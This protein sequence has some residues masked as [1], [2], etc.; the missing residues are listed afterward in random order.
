V[1]WRKYE[2]EIHDQ[3]H[4]MY[5]NAEITH[6]TT[7][8]GRYSK[9][10]RQIDILI[11]DYAAG[12][13]FKIIVDGKYYSKRIN[14]K[15]VEEFIGMMQ[16]VGADKG[17]LITQKGYSQAALN[18][19]HY[20]PSR[21]EL[22]ILNF[23]ELKEFQAFGAIPY[24]GEH[25]VL[26][27]SPFGWV[28]DI[29]H[30][31]GMLATLFQRG[32]T[33]DEAGKNKEWMYV[34]IASKTPEIKDLQS[35]IELQEN[36]VLENLP[37][38]K[39]EY[40]TSIRREDAKTALRIININSYPTLEYT[41]FVEFDDFIFFCV[42]FTPIEL[43]EKN[44]KKLEYILAKVRPIEIDVVS[45]LESRLAEAEYHFKRTDDIVEKSD[46]L[47][48][49]GQVLKQLKRFDDAEAKF[50]ASI[51]LLATSYGGIKGK[52]ELSLIRNKALNEFQDTIDQFFDLG[53]TNPTVCNDIIDLF[54]EYK[55]EDDIV[56]V[57]TEKLNDYELNK[58]A[59]GNINY[60]LGVFHSSK[61]KEAKG[62]FMA[63][64]DCFKQSVLK[65]HKVFKA[66]EINLK[67]IETKKRQKNVE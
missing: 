1:D 27:P 45:V 10:D 44:I 43:I 9:T 23:L 31:N 34:N 11:V 8:L 6:N 36:Y 14:V 32:L 29:N 25:G 12:E 17:L 64:K 54:S 40:R 41:G 22:D 50:N 16:D 57:F 53:P 58:E 62:Y 28:I 48:G 46:I 4:E 35:F 26:M 38:A 24:S 18:R 2:K 21:I 19:A 42:L 51:A 52:L 66:I 33:L 49:Q 37:N 55:R 5:P 59:Q 30:T 47:I 3:F 67:R 60:H 56:T 65:D 63:A 20:D 15:E 7:L 13:R 39:F 61:G